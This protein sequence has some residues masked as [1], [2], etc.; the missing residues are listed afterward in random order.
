[1]ACI[2]IEREWEAFLIEFN[3]LVDGRKFKLLLATQKRNLIMQ[4]CYAIA[5]AT[6]DVASSVASGRAS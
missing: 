3:N 1:V 6:S 5:T 4:C 2:R